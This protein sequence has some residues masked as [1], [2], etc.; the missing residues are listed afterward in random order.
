MDASQWGPALLTIERLCDIVD[1][2]CNFELGDEF[3]PLFLL[4][5]L[6]VN[7]VLEATLEPSTPVVEARLKEMFQALQW[8]DRISLY[9]YLAVISV[10]RQIAGIVFG[11]LARPILQQGVALKLVPMAK[12][13]PPVEG[14]KRIQWEPASNRTDRSGRSLAASPISIY[15]PPSEVLELDRLTPTEFEPN[16]LYV[17]K[18]TRNRAGF[19]AIITSHG[20]LHIFQIATMSLY[21]IESK[22]VYAIKDG[23]KNFFSEEVLRGLPPKTMWRYVFVVPPGKRIVGQCKSGVAEFLTGVSLFS[24]EL[25]VEKWTWVV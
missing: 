9:Q 21:E 10:A 24:A 4:R 16:R 13:S 20:F 6:D 1:K 5:R 22:S 25:D 8:D 7:E 14:E 19:D 23:I 2:A 12:R 11:S 18:S 17:P 15:F 3:V